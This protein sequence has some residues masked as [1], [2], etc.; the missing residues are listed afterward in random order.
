MRMAV[1]LGTKENQQ[2]RCCRDKGN[3]GVRSRSRGSTAS[4]RYL[5][6]QLIELEV[7]KTAL[8]RFGRMAVRTGKGMLGEDRAGGR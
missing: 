6:D 5:S 3:C 1:E 4:G 7:A 2:T 8:A